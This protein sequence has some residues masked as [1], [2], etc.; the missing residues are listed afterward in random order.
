MSR[1]DVKAP[2]TLKSLGSFKV[3]VSVSE[4]AASRLGLGSEGLVHIPAYCSPGVCWYH[5]NGKILVLVSQ[6]N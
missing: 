1:Q 4:A 2:E 3:S 5:T 6:G